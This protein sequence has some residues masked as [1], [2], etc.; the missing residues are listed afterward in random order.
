MVG[1]KARPPR[2]RTPTPS[3]GTSLP[4]APRGGKGLGRNP[5]PQ[6]FRLPRRAGPPR[7][8]AL[9]T[10]GLCPQPHRTR[11]HWVSVTRARGQSRRDSHPPG[12]PW[13][14]LAADAHASS[15]RDRT[16]AC[17]LRSSR[18]NGRHPPRPPPLA[19][20]TQNPAPGPPVGL[21]HPAEAPGSVVA[22]KAPAH[23]PPVFT[24]TGAGD[25]R[26]ARGGGGGLYLRSRS[27]KS[28]YNWPKTVY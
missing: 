10:V 3:G 8:L 17:P 19:G 13:R 6:L 16:P 27:F 28:R 18:E 4:A 11:Q 14:R 15:F 23:K 25:L 7:P 24:A 1:G 21:A 26:A 20:S 2:R 9:N 12:S 5:A 22:P